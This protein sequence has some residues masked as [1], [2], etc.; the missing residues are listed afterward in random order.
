VYK[1]FLYN[2]T[3]NDVT[4]EDNNRAENI[5]NNFFELMDKYFSQK[6]LELNND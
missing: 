3:S 6:K 1:A 2:E 5:T 4:T